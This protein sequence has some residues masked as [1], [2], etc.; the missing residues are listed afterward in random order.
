MRVMR[1][2]RLPAPG[3]PEATAGMRA[4]PQGGIRGART[5]TL[6]LEAM[7]KLYRSGVSFERIGTMT[8]MTGNGVRYHLQKRW[9]G[10]AYNRA[11]TKTL[12]LR[13]TRARTQ[14]GRPL[15]HAL[16]M[17]RCFRPKLYAKAL[18]HGAPKLA[19]P[20]RW[21]KEWRCDCPSCRS[22]RSVFA[23]HKGRQRSSW[24]WKCSLC[25]A[26]GVVNARR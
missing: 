1:D 10:E 9:P 6:D 18:L 19:N 24:S 15:K 4:M 12:S 22:P 3:I 5:R 13:L 11:V 23:R 14:G 16:A 20:E 7:A 2:K 21:G 8:G 26:E 25:D 17:L